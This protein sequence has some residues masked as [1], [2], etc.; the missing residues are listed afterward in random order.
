MSDKFNNPRVASFTV[1]GVYGAS[2][3]DAAINPTFVDKILKN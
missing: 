2:P 3:K 1:Y